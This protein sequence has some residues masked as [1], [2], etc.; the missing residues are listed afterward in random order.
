V[1]KDKI[2]DYSATNGSNTDVGGINIDE[3]CDPSVI[4]NAIREVMTHLKE[5]SAGTFP[6]ED[7]FTVGDPADLTKRVRLD[8]GNVTA[9]QTRVMGVQDRDM[10]LGITRGTSQATTSGTSIDFTSI[11]SWVRRITIA[12]TGVSLSGTNN[13][14]VQIGDSGGLETT[15][16]ISS[17]SQLP[18]GAAII[19]ANSTAGFIIAVAAAAAIVSGT[20]TLVNTTGD[21][22]VASHTVKISTLTT[23]VG[24][25]NMTLSATLDRLSIVMTGADSFDAGAINI[26]YE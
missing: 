4:N 6:V 12:F 2:T 11:P 18:N 8:A 13:I 9:G 23:S 14:A 7:T 10:T 21:T 19:T 26:F 16:Y 15:G 20:M 17:S 25:G 1:A 22:W 3:G 24:G 5:A